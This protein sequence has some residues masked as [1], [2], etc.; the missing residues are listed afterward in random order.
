[1]PSA[2]S[3]DAPAPS[4]EEQRRLL[5]T[6]IGDLLRLE[7]RLTRGK[8]PSSAAIFNGRLLVLYE[9][10]N[11]IAHNIELPLDMQALGQELLQ[12]RLEWLRSRVWSL[13][14]TDSST[15]SDG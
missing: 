12:R 10:T 1:M 15:S 3:P 9:L 13:P 14:L 6:C 8:L 11:A 4:I 2:P 7:T 5:R